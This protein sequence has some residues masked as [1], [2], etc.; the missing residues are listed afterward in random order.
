VTGSRRGRD[1]TGGRGITGGQCGDN[2]IG[3]GEGE[4]RDTDREGSEK[5]CSEGNHVGSRVSSER[6]TFKG[7][8]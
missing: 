6:L 3:T 5:E 1:M 8:S 7:W 4:S 2:D